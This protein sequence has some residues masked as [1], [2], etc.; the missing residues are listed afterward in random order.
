MRPSAER[1][2]MDPDPAEEEEPTAG[3]PTDE[4]EAEETDD[5]T[6]AADPETV[7]DAAAEI[8]DRVV[9]GRRSG[10]DA[11]A[12]ET[13]ADGEGAD[14]G[15]NVTIDADGP[16]PL[17]ISLPDGSE[18][19]AAAIRSNREML[20]APAE[21]GL[22]PAEAVTELR[23]TVDRLAED[24]PDDLT[25][26]L[27]GLETATERLADR[28]ARQD[29]E[30]RELREVVRSLAEILG[31]SVEFQESATDGDDAAAGESDA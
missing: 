22:A 21:N 9:G 6:A 8:A 4:S 17:T 18:S 14:A 15:A 31:A 30:I 29:R 20:S 13:S 12:G 10:E 7:A 24:R 23:E 19:V 3:A 2:R 27:A 1:T 16:E 5:A 11:G 28:V 25:S 26:E